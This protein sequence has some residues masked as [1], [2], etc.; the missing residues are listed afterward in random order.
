MLEHTNNKSLITHIYPKLPPIGDRDEQ[1]TFIPEFTQQ[2]I[3]DEREGYVW[4]ELRELTFEDTP[5][6]IFVALHETENN[7]VVQRESFKG[8][9]EKQETEAGRVRFLPNLKLLR[10]VA[11]EGKVVSNE[12]L[13]PWNLGVRQC[14]DEVIKRCS[15]RRNADD[16][17]EPPLALVLWQ[18]DYWHKHRGVDYLRYLSKVTQACPDLPIYIFHDY[19]T[20]KYGVEREG[21]SNKQDYT[22]ST[23]PDHDE[24]DVLEHLLAKDALTMMSG[25]SYTGKTHLAISM[26]LS[27][28]TGEAWLDTFKVPQTTPVTYFVPEL[29]SGRF[30]KFMTRIAPPEVWKQNEDRFIVRPLD[31][32]LLLLDSEEMIAK[33]RGRYVFLD[34]LGYFM[35]VDDSSSYSAAIEFA[36]KINHLIKEGCLGVCGLYHPPK[37]SKNKKETG[38]VMTLENQILGSAGY[39]GLLRSCL[40]VRNL[41]KDP[42]M[43]LWVYVQGLKNPGLG[44]PFQIK[45]L[46]LEYLGESPYLSELLK[47]DSKRE[48][49]IAMLKEGKKRDEICK[50]LNMSSKTLTKIK[51]GELEFDSNDGGEEML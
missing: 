21:S 46:P 42:N 30:K 23:L 10:K 11:K 1:G 20:D 8:R 48:Q 19:H 16:E 37:Y 31:C 7:R 28:I 15:F 34:T 47:T 13:L 32:D 24:E 12:E 17:L 2:P 36:K 43:G 38:N 29:S 33:C 49:A 41:H 22:F 3:S 25:P 35:G 18:P 50:A 9:F 27:L 26:G 45:G 4:D 6:A 40:G 51:Q 5:G 14:A 44:K 39:G